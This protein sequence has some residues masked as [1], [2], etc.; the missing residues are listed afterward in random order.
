MLDFHHPELLLLGL[1]VP[2]LGW[3]WLTRRHGSL[4]H[5]TVSTLTD[6]PGGRGQFAFWCGFALRMLSLICLVIAAAGPRWPD[7]KTRIQTEGI[8]IV[9]MVDVSGSM[10]TKD[11]EWRGGAITRLD[12]VKKAFRLFVAGGEGLEGRPTDEIGLVVFA[13][14]PET[15]SPLTLSHSALLRAMDEQKPVTIPGDSETNL[16]DG[17]ALGVHR[18]KNAG[19]RRKVLILLSDGEHNVEEPASQW[20]MPRAIRIAQAEGVPIYTIDAAGT[21]VSVAEGT[22][23]T[24]SLDERERAVRTLRQ[25]AENTGGQYFR[26][27][28]TEALLDVYQVIDRKERAPI[29]SYQYRRY[30]EAYPWLGLAAFVF[31]VSVLSLEMTLLRRVP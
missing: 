10:G 8:A 14:L 25:I 11:F 31:F 24:A 9:M 19:Q 17:M 1:A 4:R 16:I 22:Q 3:W 20:K 27:D 29:E 26:A 6:L 2:P 13:A 30:Y 12:A 23:Q 7:L 15:A 18:L 28:N 5:P 21:G